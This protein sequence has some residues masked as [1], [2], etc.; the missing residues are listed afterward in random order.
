MFRVSFIISLF[1]LRAVFV[2]TVKD[3]FLAHA[4]SGGKF[5]VLQEVEDLSVAANIIADPVEGGDDFECESVAAHIIADPVEGDDFECEDALQKQRTLPVCSL[6]P[7]LVPS[8]D[9]VVV[10]KK[11]LDHKRKRVRDGIV[12]K[13]DIVLARRIRGES[14][15]Y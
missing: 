1:L 2:S 5:S 15:F 3:G 7:L 12:M 14:G 13:T 9:K 8:K 4:S 10:S 6:D 11:C